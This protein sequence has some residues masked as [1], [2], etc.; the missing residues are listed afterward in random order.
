MKEI[1]VFDKEEDIYKILGWKYT[2]DSKKEKLRDKL[3][4]ANFNLDDWDIGFACK[5][6]LGHMVHDEAD[7]SDEWYEW[8]D[9]VWWLGMRMENYCVGYHHVEYGGY[10]WYTFHHS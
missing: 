4:D 9:D 6:P 10:H 8:Y 2:N 5:E 1:I 7:Y 3:W